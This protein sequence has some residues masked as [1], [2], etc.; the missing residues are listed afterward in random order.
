MGGLL[1]S[2]ALTA[3]RNHQAVLRNLH[4]ANCVSLH[5]REASARGRQ[6]ENEAKQIA[7]P[8]ILLIDG[9]GRLHDAPN[10]RVVQRELVS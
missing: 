7:V 10:V 5:L 8:T 4:V 1:F 6:N 9:C 3:S 2:T